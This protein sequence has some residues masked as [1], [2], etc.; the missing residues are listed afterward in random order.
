MNERKE[1]KVK[2]RVDR[3]ALGQGEVWKQ[4]ERKGEEGNRGRQ[5]GGYEGKRVWWEEDEEDR[6]EGMMRGSK[7]R[8]TRKKEWRVWRKE[9]ME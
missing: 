4:E 6:K 7:P 1:K 5:K 9:V 3:I 2:W 8:K